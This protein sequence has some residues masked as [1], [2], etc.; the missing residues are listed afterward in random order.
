MSRRYQPV[1]DPYSVP[2]D[3]YGS[4]PGGDLYPE[5]DPYLLR[6]SYR[7][8]NHYKDRDPAYYSGL[9][10]RESYTGRHNRSEYPRHDRHHR[11][12]DDRRHSKRHTNRRKKG[13]LLD[14]AE[15]WIDEGIKFIQEMFHGFLSSNRGVV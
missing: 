14:D 6:D 11:K 4:G 13:G 3:A 15:R 1:G 8:N 9:D 7:E 5:R 12:H 10:R 2:R